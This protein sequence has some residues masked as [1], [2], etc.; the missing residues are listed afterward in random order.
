MVLVTFGSRF[1]PGSA[2]PPPAFHNT[3]LE[4]QRESKVPFEVVYLLANRNDWYMS[5]IRD[6]GTLDE[7]V[8]RLRDLIAGRPSVFVGNSMGGYAALAFGYL[9]PATRVLAFSPQ[10][11]Y[12]PSE[13]RWDV[14]IDLIPIRRIIHKSKFTTKATLVVGSD[15]LL[16]VHYAKQLQG[17]R[18][19]RV[20]SIEKCG[21]DV[22]TYLRKR[23]ELRRM[24]L[25]EVTA[26]SA[27][28]SGLQRPSGV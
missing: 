20:S 21:H 26:L 25:D 13:S 5:G 1:Q 12:D 15:D 3:M 8:S 14:P 9:V 16:D 6:F 18:G 19:V 10:T 22:A 23:R 17:L 27:T 4:V 28:A 7:S 2:A 24:I 11:C